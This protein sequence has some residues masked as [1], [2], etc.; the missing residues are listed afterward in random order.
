MPEQFFDF[1]RHVGCGAIGV[2]SRYN[3]AIYGGLVEP[4]DI[5][6]EEDAAELSGIMLFGDDCAGWC[7]GFVM[8]TG[9]VVKIDSS[10]KHVEELADD[11][12]GFIFARISE[13]SSW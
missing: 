4:Y 2:P 9:C 7:A 5:Y 3:F 8:A 13:I 11:F 10:D 6:S 12:Y 1:L